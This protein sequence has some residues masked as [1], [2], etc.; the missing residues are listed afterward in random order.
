MSARRKIGVLVGVGLL[1]VAVWQIGDAIVIHGKAWMAQVLLDRAWSQTLAGERNARPWPWADTRPVAR[2]EVP[3]LGIDH[4]VLAGAS[5]RVLAFGPGHMDGTASPGAPGNSVINGHRDTHFS[6]LD[7]LEAGD[8]VRV[9]T[10][11]SG[12]VDYQV[13]DVRVVDS[14]TARLAE[15]ADPMLTL[16]TCYPFGAVT[17]GGALRYS[18]TA[19]AAAPATD[20]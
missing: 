20:S 12:M 16:V 10:A 15:S 7:D 13:T 19:V 4:I 2:L 18:V 1:G 9:Q 5:G 17:T 6:F 3:R 8:M 11:A 14:R